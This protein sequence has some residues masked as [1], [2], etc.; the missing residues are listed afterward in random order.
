MSRTTR[1]IW[2]ALW[3]IGLAWGLVA[4]Y[5]SIRNHVP[6]NHFLDLLVGLA[7]MS[8]GLIAWARRPDGRV[9]ELL[10]LAGFAWFIGNY[11]N[12]DVPAVFSLAHAFEGLS[13]VPLVHAILAYPSGRVQTRLERSYLAILWTWVLFVG[14]INAISVDPAYDLRCPRCIH[15]G[16]VLFHTNTFVSAINRADDVLSIAF[17][18]AGL[19]LIFLRSRRETPAV[20]RSLSALWVAA[21]ALGLA[22][23]AQGFDDA[24]GLTGVPHAAVN[25]TQRMMNIAVPFALLF[26]LLKIRLVRSSVG[27]MMVALGH[28]PEP[29]RLRDA[30]AQTLGDPSLQVAYKLP[31]DGYIDADG[32]PIELPADPRAATI[33]DRNGEAI[34]ALIHDPI[35]SEQREVVE[36]AGAAARLAIENE[37]LRAEV[38]AQLEEV[39]AS[40]ARIVEAG[41]VERIRVERN[42]H[43][44][45]QQRLLSLSLALRMAEQRLEDSNDPELRT[46]LVAAKVELDSAIAEIREL[47]RGIHPAILTDEGLTAALESLAER[48][49][50]PSRI[51]ASPAQRLPALVEVTAYFIVS[52]AIANAAKHARA[53]RILIA[54]EVHDGSLCLDVSDDGVGGA[55]SDGSGLRGL[56]DRVAAL[57][58]TLEIESPRGGGTRV[59]A[60]LPCA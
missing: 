47:A 46:S 29:G 44:G 57:G 26:G 41:D 4:E 30:L 11:A 25:S 9:G 34:A 10:T 22:F 21:T 33:L 36:A 31:D 17:P 32:R 1:G 6:E 35:L 52:E 51:I 14:V 49:P 54:A 13:V 37:R 60:E 7:L 3:P 45:A 39:R 19:T 55:S 53:T 24:L 56:R 48:A 40:R 18:I 20:R 58:G 59:R 43:D 12:A 28:Q 2:F 8:A 5:F 27:N 50:V 23:V 42:L 15:G 38:R 16:L